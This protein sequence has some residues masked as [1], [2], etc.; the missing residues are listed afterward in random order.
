M[1]QM[2]YILTEYAM[3]IATGWAGIMLIIMAITLHRINKSI[4]LQKKA[5]KQLQEEI[6]EVRLQIELQE[7]HAE[8]LQIAAEMEKAA[9][10][11]EASGSENWTKEQ[12]TLVNAVLGEVFS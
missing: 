4:R 9:G 12:E 5:A 1:E 10:E 7:Q 2:Q 6:K 11:G 8:N 3:Y